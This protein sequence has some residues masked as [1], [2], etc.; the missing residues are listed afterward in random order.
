MR[1]NLKNILE[2]STTQNN[3]SHNP[4]DQRSMLENMRMQIELLEKQTKR[5]EKLLKVQGGKLDMNRNVAANEE[6]NFMY[7]QA[8]ESKLAFLSNI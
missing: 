2:P 3:N 5:K 1:R 4:A 6:I 8:I 7:L